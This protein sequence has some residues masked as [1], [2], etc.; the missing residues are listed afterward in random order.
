MVVAS[1]WALHTDPDTWDDPLTFNP[2][3]F[4]GDDDELLS[5]QNFIP[6]Q[7]GNVLY[8]LIVVY[9]DNFIIKNISGKR[10]CPGD[11]LARSMMFL[12][13]TNILINF[14]LTLDE[15][16]SRLEGDMGI[17]LQTPPYKIFLQPLN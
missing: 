10:M 7:T 5:P 14:K 9:V 6:F 3:R 15:I 4:I 11:D 8:M 12:Y 1:Q 2:T 17:T 16:P 13:S